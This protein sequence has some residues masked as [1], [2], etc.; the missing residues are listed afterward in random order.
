MFAARYFASRYF[1]RRYFPAPATVVQPALVVVGGRPARRRDTIEV[2]PHAVTGVL[3]AWFPAW[4]C[5]AV[6]IVQPVHAIGTLSAAWT[7]TWHAAGTGAI[8]PVSVRGR[9]AVE[10]PEWAFSGAG[11]VRKAPER[12]KAA[13][14]EAVLEA[15]YAGLIGRA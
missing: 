13:D 8:Q 9:L 6:G 1:A 10:L 14:D 5:E 7:G 12:P 3:E 15:Y 11:L 2:R 4:E